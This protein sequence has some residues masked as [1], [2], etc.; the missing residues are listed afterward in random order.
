MLSWICVCDFFVYSEKC[1]QTVLLPEPNKRIEESVTGRLHHMQ[2][3]QVLSERN[4]LRADLGDLVLLPIA[5]MLLENHWEYLSNCA[6]Q[7]FPRLVR[8]FYGH[9]IVTHDDDHVLIM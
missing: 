1:L 4:L 5:Q 6:C 7:A 3:R 9:M 2:S 8:D